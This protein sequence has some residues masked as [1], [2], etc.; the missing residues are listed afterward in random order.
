MKKI[1]F[2]SFFL[3]TTVI[4]TESCT[5]KA[6]TEASTEKVIT[7]QDNT[8]SKKPQQTKNKEGV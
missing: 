1:Y 2:L 7:T 8:K 4:L 3:L 6:K 5:N